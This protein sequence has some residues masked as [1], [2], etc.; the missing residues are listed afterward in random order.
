[1]ISKK[2]FEEYNRGA[3]EI[4]DGAASAVEQRVLGWCRSH[5]GAS[6]A[7]KREAAKLIMEGFVQ[8]YDDKA[9]EFASQWYDY[10]AEQGGARLRQAVTT[11]VYEPGSV[12]DVARYQAKKLAKEGDAAFAR[13]CGEF[14]RN[15][16]FRSLNE[17][18][19]ANVGRDRDKG[20]AFARVPAGTETCTF[21]L[22]LAS[23]GAVYHTRKTAGEFKHF[24]RNCDCKVVPSFEGDPDAELVQGVKPRELYGKWWLFEKIDATE[25]LSSAERDEMKRLVLDGGELPEKVRE[26]NPSAHMRKA[27]RASSGWISAGVRLDAEV[28]AHGFKDVTDFYEYLGS[29]RTRAEIDE[30][31]ALG[32]TILGNSDATPKFYELA[33]GYLR[34]SANLVDGAKPSV[35]E[36]LGAVE[37]EIDAPLP[38]GTTSTSSVTGRFKAYALP[39]GRRF[40][41]KADMDQS[42]QDMTPERLLS[43]YEKVPEHIKDRMQKEIYVV[44]YANPQ[45][46][47][48]RTRYRNFAGSYATGGI[49][50][51]L[52]AYT[53][54]DDSYLER[55]LCHETGH[56]VDIEE[57]SAG[58]ALSSGR[59]WEDAVM[60]DYGHSK[61]THPTK[62]AANSASEDFAESVALYTVDSEKFR[63]DFPYRASVLD[64]VFG[65]GNSADSPAN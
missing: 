13:A 59:V 23:R 19:I 28:K 63:R 43:I 47:Y 41:F 17:T 16:A 64:K 9:A 5:E 3:A 50:I 42:R 40:L 52:W 18:I 57:A 53:G 56:L 32:D 35:F 15:D 1:M 10:R 22:M 62:Y 30:A 25:G 4:G 7:E 33:K 46:E 26:T 27:G 54:H 44:D 48:W 8:A 65:G 45:D 34:K 49:E 29:R 31:T 61:K 39:S 11:T 24:H 38:T 51:T 6:V 14:A 20:A 12:D 37:A 58:E 55:T 36:R 2:E 21:C 60:K